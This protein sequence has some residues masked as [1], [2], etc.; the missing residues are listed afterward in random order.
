MKLHPFLSLFSSPS[1]AL[2]ILRGVL[3]IQRSQLQVR[4]APSWSA[5]H[6]SPGRENR[7]ALPAALAHRW[8]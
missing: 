5:V 2:A 4:A 3:G 6:C 7:A 8:V 1:S